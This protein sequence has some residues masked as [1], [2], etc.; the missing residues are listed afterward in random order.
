ME[1]SKIVIH[2]LA[3]CEALLSIINLFYF[4][5]SFVVCVNMA[6]NYRAVQLRYLRYKLGVQKI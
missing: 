5:C 6:S 3:L 2:F 4:I 1:E